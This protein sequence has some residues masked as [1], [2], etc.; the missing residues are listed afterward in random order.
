MM[1]KMFLF[2]LGFA[3]VVIGISLVLCN[4]DA[5]VIVFRGIV[6]SAVAVLGL[7]VMFAASLKR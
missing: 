7:V 3:V 5:A 6:P 4:W 1:N 2:S